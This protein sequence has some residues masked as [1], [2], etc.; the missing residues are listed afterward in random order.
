MNE[1]TK[2]TAILK[3]SSEIKSEDL[4]F[5]EQ[6]LKRLLTLEKAYNSQPSNTRVNINVTKSGTSSFNPAKQFGNIYSGFSAFPDSTFSLPKISNYQLSNIT[7]LRLNLSLDFRPEYTFF[8]AKP[9]NTLVLPV[10]LH[11]GQYDYKYPQNSLSA[12]GTIIDM[13]PYIYIPV[14]NLTVIPDP[15]TTAVSFQ[16]ER[17][18]TVLNLNETIP[19]RNNI[20]IPTNF[21]YPDMSLDNTK[22]TQDQYST[23]LNQDNVM[24]FGVYCYVDDVIATGTTGDAD[25][26]TTYIS[27]TITWLIN[28]TFSYF[29]LLS[30]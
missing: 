1:N 11:F 2:P 26:V 22:I 28:A 10:Y 20:I 25:Y 4:T 15:S 16:F 18:E 17:Y 6:I 7:L 23:L 13:S 29:G 3:T 19:S 21:M 14:G 8:V 27:G 9:D 30:S 12:T 5:N 24:M